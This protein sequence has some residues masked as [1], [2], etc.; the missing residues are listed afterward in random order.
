MS[1]K[2]LY[3]KAIEGDQEGETCNREGC[4]G[5]IEKREQDPCYCHENPPCKSCCQNYEY[6]PECGW[7]PEQP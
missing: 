6:C 4:A 5:V 3:R 7:E 2:S 1:D